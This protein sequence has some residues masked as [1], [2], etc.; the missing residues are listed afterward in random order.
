MIEIYTENIVLPSNLDADRMREGLRQVL[1]DMGCAQDRVNVIFV[2]D[3]GIRRLN[4]TYREIDAPTDVL[5]FDLRDERI[6][7]EE[8]TGEVYVSLQRAAEQAAQAGI[9]LR[10][11][12]VHLAVHGLLHLAGFDDATAAERQC[13]ENGTRR[14]VRRMLATENDDRATGPSEGV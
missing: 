4:R 6:R 3:E 7:P 12:V 13:M 14:Y 8:V 9:S 1:L 10:E 5:A 11:E 2:D